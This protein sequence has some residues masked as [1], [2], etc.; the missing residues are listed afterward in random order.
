MNPED[1]HMAI[2]STLAAKGEVDVADLSRTLAV[3]AATIRRDLAL[4]ESGDVLRRTHGGA[5]RTNFAYELP[6]R[7]RESY[8]ESEKLAIATVAASYVKA[9]MQVGL[10]GGTTLSKV[11]RALGPGPAIKVVTNSLS[12]ACEFAQWS[13]H[14]LV[15]TGGY[16]RSSSYE[17][18]GPMAD[19][20]IAEFNLELCILGAEGVS[21]AGIFTHDHTEAATNRE[22]IAASEKRIVVV[23][24]TKLD[25][26]KFSRI[27]ALDSVD[28][29]I[30]VG[31]PSKELAA[32]LT[33][34]NVELVLSDAVSSVEPLSVVS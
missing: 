27:C 16:V 12:V 25:K 29:L 2:L 6:L 23:D 33:K 22:M 3:S 26:T 28:V 7:Y 10:T 14:T 11:G 4:L 5:V 30:T 24:H 31:E 34:N 8:Q 18:V 21:E 13:Q 19:R 9:N 15:V 17:M 20:C 1:R 32:A